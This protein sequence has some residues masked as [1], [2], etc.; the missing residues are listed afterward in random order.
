MKKITLTILLTAS[1]LII[2]A[3]EKC[4]RGCNG[5][6][7]CTACKNCSGCKHCAKEGGS[8]GVCDSKSSS[9]TYSI[10]KKHSVSHKKT[11]TTHSKSYKRK[12]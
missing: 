8:C 5:S 11:S 6:A 4:G 12:K 2:S 9:T 10:P 1:F 3:H 7:N